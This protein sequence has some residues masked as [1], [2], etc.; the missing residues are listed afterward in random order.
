MGQ[1]RAYRS[2]ASY[3]ADAYSTDW[4][5]VKE[6]MQGNTIRHWELKD[7]SVGSETNSDGIYFI[8]ADGNFKWKWVEHKLKPKRSV[9]RTI[10]ATPQV[11]R[12]TDSGWTSA[13]SLP[14]KDKVV[15]VRLL[16]GRTSTAYVNNNDEWKLDF[17]RDSYKGGSTISNMKEWKDI[18]I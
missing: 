16:D 9:K 2:W 18:S 6:D 17:N 3:K 4:L 11:V 13:K 14:E 15:V 12:S 8:D 10:K 1:G 7:S 5:V